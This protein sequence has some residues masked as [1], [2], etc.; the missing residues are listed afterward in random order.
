MNEPRTISELSAEER[1][2]LDY[3]V[4]AVEP[5][6]DVWV[7]DHIPC[8]QVKIQT[9]AG[10]VEVALL[11]C[12]DVAYLVDVAKESPTAMAAVLH[13]VYGLRAMQNLIDGH[14]QATPDQIKAAREQYAHDPHDIEID[15]GAAISATDDGTWVQAWVWVPHPEP[16]NPV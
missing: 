9:E 16:K 11:W 3:R 8:R 10:E 4:L 5:V 15:D 13:K 6:G 12:G 14:G 1:K 2:L 7:D